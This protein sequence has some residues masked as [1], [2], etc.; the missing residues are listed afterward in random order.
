MNKR[1]KNTTSANAG[2]G[3]IVGIPGVGIPTGAAVAPHTDANRWQ[4]QSVLS[5]RATGADAATLP[6]GDKFAVIMRAAITNPGG[7]NVR[8]LQIGG[9][10]T[11]S[12]EFRCFNGTF[13]AVIQDASANQKDYTAG[14]V[15][16]T[17]KDYCVVW[18]SGTF[19]IYVNAVAQTPVKN[20]DATLTSNLVRD[21]T[22]GITVGA[23]QNLTQFANMYVNELAIFK[24][25]SFTSDDVTEA[26]NSGTFPNL[27]GHT[28]AAFLK[29]WW[30]GEDASD[31]NTNFV[32]VVGGLT[33]TGVNTT[34]VST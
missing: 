17:T 30:T 33:L 3:S 34:L 16:G 27:T 26:Y 23:R 12:L 1:R 29:H 31:T 15:D 22:E 8:A 24:D 10:T 13:R 11:F 20:A 28:K 6:S 14:T 2:S 7:T 5:S 25:T 18:D 4:F 32:D 21:S 19:T 9:V